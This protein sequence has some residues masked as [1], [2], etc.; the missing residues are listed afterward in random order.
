M[1]VAIGFGFPSHW[2]IN[3]REI[4]GPIIK[5]S[6]CNHEISFDSHLKTALKSKFKNKTSSKAHFSEIIGRR[7]TQISIIHDYYSGEHSM[8]AFSRKI[9]VAKH[10]VSFCRNC[11]FTLST[12]RCSYGTF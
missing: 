10:S 6:N 3:W 2:L 12:L 4:F 7:E 8:S 11:S 1:Q 9:S 5:R